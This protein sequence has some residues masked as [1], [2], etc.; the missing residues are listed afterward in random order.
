M[1][2]KPTRAHCRNIKDDKDGRKRGH[3]QGTP[4]NI[5]L[6]KEPTG[7]IAVNAQGT[8]R[9]LVKNP[10]RTTY[11]TAA[12]VLAA[13]QPLA[14]PRTPPTVVSRRTP[15][16]PPTV[17][18]RNPQLAGL[19]DRDW[20]IARV[21]ANRMLNKVKIIQRAYRDK[22]QRGGQRPA[23]MDSE[24]VSHLDTPTPDRN[25]STGRFVSS[26]SSRRSSRRRSSLIRQPVFS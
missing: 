22:H 19:S 25:P 11:T 16:T 5:S 21:M 20:H 9:R 26:K 4:G 1:A 23:P 2:K 3:C 6:A 13:K 8:V 15:P 17:V 24:G 18:S 12:K 7:R 10:V 14:Q